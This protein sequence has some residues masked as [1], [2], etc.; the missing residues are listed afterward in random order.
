[1]CTGIAV[2][3]VFWAVLLSSAP[4]AFAVAASLL[5]P[6]ISGTEAS[7]A[8]IQVLEDR[9]TA[10]LAQIAR[11]MGGPALGPEGHSTPATPGSE[12]STSSTS[13]A[14]R[15]GGARHQVA[16]LKREAKQ[17]FRRRQAGVW[18]FDPFAASPARVYATAL[19]SFAVLFMCM[20]AAASVS[21]LLNGLQL[22]RLEGVVCVGGLFLAIIWMGTEWG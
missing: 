15:A 19:P 11:H 3:A 16:R 18:L 17:R 1:M 9:K 7:A 8:C 12:V 4:R 22:N 21:E 14:S 5:V 6:P 2:M 10:R 20:A 13:E